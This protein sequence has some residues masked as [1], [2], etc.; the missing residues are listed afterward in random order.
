MLGAVVVEPRPPRLERPAGVSSLHAGN[1][2]L[3]GTPRS[4]SAERR[5]FRSRG[6]AARSQSAGGLS[7]GAGPAPPPGRLAPAPRPRSGPAFPHVSAAEGRRLS[8]SGPASGPAPS[9]QRVLSAAPGSGPAP[10]CSRAGCRG[11]GCA[12]SARLWL[13][14]VAAGVGAASAPRRRSGWRTRRRPRGGG[15]GLTS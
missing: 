1:G 5:H 11:P 12:R 8:R 10:R 2:S 14:E 7:P 9:A 6:A 4:S 13:P 15:W 3:S